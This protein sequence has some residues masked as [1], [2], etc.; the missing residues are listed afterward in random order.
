MRLLFTPQLKSFTIFNIK[1]ILSSAEIEC[2]YPTLPLRFNLLTVPT[3]TMRQDK[4]VRGLEIRKE[5]E[6]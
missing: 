2:D 6:K 1:S 4:E 5:E 3:Q